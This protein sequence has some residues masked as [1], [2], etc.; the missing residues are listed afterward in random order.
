[1]YQGQKRGTLKQKL[2]FLFFFF[3]KFRFKYDCLFIFDMTIVSSLSADPHTLRNIYSNFAFTALFSQIF[4]Y[5]VNNNFSSVL[6]VG[7]IQ[8]KSGFWAM[9][10]SLHHCSLSLLLL[11]LSISARGSSSG[12]LAA[13]LTHRYHKMIKPQNR[14][15]AL[16]IFL[17]QFVF[18]GGISKSSPLNV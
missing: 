15:P 2:C 6:L 1:M 8:S 13:S 17:C 14:N 10:T 7:F 16:S 18:P 9:F 3:S 11:R 12:V 5:L 4:I